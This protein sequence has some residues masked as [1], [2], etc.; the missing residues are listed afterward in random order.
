MSAP[1]STTYMGRLHK[2]LCE[3][4]LD[5]L[6]GEVVLDDHG[7]PVTDDFGQ[8][9]FSRP[10][11]Q[12]LKEVREFLKDNGIDSEPLDGSPVAQISSMARVYEDELDNP[13]ILKQL[14]ETVHQ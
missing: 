10:T 13:P 2:K 1:V 11:P 7:N 6:K 4:L 14:T 8:Q 5:A 12:L 3:V 9:K